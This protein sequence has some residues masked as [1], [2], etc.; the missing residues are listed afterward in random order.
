MRSSAFHV[1]PPSAWQAPGGFANQLFAHK[2]NGHIITHIVPMQSFVSWSWK[3]LLVMQ[4]IF[5]DVL[6]ELTWSLQKVLQMVDHAN[7]LQLSIDHNPLHT[8]DANLK[9]VAKWKERW[10][11]Y[12]VYDVVLIAGKNTLRP[13]QASG[14]HNSS[15]QTVTSSL[16]CPMPQAS[17]RHNFKHTN[18][19]ELTN[20]S[21]AKLILTQP[22]V[23]YPRLPRF[24]LPWV[25]V[26][27]DLLGWC[28]GLSYSG[29]NCSSS[30]IALLFQDT[31][32]I[33]CSVC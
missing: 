33:K 12:K 3:Y 27:L 30:Y 28:S 7:I 4:N 1:D 6:F 32:C 17:G 22:V 20:M 29:F 5:L 26:P 31:K 21:N 13:A 11:W 19:D 14:R 8:L 10:W 23:M 25:A 2:F 18:C 15:T 9:H 24:V 16:T